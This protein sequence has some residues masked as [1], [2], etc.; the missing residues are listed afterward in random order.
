MMIQHYVD[1]H[2]LNMD[3]AL[4]WNVSVCL[5]IAVA[6]SVVACRLFFFHFHYHTISKFLVVV[7]TSYHFENHP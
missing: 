1:A 5:S 4:I 2:F 3:I 6:F 7:F